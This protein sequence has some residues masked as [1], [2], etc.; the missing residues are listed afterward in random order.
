MTSTDSNRQWWTATWP[1][2]RAEWLRLGL[3]L[4]AVVTGGVVVGEILTNWSGLSSLIDLDAR[5]SQNLADGRTETGNDLAPWAAFIAD[6]PVKIALSIAIAGFF[7][8]KFRRWHEAVMIGLPLIFEAVAFISITF[9]V[10]RPRP[11]VERLLESPV[12]T[13][14][15]SGHVAAATVYAAIAV[16]VFWHSQ[17]IWVRAVAVA[18]AAAAPLIVAWAR[19]YQGMHYLTDVIAGMVLGSVSVAIAVWVLGRPAPTHQSEQHDSDHHGS[20]HHGS[21]QPMEALS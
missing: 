5:I 12:D 15:P 21:Q 19:L 6:T 7:L 17:S 3:A 8:W 2:T 10:R 1:L 4:V 16:I 20:E 14:F 18:L 13:S 11:D 9:I